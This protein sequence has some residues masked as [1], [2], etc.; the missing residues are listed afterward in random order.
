MTG[1]HPTISVVIPTRNEEAQIGA[2][3]EAV[4]GAARLF[5]PND[6]S[7]VEVI[8]VDNQST[9]A[10]AEV[11]SAIAARAPQVVL[12][13]SPRLGA[14]KARNDGSA[15][16]RGT[17]LVFVDADTWIPADTLQRVRHLVDDEGIEAGI[18]RLAGQE[19]GLRSRLW[20][21]FWGAA[22][23]LP[24]AKAKA[25]PA[26][27]FCTRTVFDELGPFDEEVLIGEEW[28]ILAELWRRRPRS[29]IYDRSITALSSSRR[30]ELRPFGYT[31]TFLRYVWAVLHHSGRIHH[32]DTVR[33]RPHAGEA[34][35]C[36]R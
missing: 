6:A 9:D 28:P 12:L 23:H 26:A 25:M 4:L 14:P 32:P 15:Q 17:I 36:P 3:L 11:V 8:V 34:R 29:F 30:M 19:K 16:A 31:R 1:Q 20:W 24:I 5:A 10:T 27:M 22:R 7:S 33:Q 18:F 2:T 21:A 13:S 35:S